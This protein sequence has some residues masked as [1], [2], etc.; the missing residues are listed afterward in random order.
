M[1]DRK[2][3]I[4]QAIVDDYVA[5]AT[6][7]GSRTIARKYLPELSSA[8]I[9]NEM[10][11]L[12][13]MGYLSQPHVSAGRVPSSKAYRLYVDMLLAKGIQQSA[14]EEAVKSAFQTRISHLED[15][16]RSAAQALAELTR[17]ASFVLM[18]RQES[19]RIAN[20]QLVP[21]S[22]AL[23]L[24]VI[25]TDGGII[26]DT[27]VKVSERLDAD[28]LYAISKMLSEQFSGRTLQEVQTA[29][30]Q[31]AGQSPGDPQVLQGIMDLST[32]MD[33]QNAEDQLTICGTHNILGFP[34][35]QEA[36]K[37]RQ[38]LY[39]LDDKE[40][41]LNLVRDTRGEELLVHIGPE[42]GIE[43]MRSCS[44]AVAEYRFSRGQRGTIGL[45]GP[46]RMPYQSIFST[47]RM[48][49]QVMN[50]ILSN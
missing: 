1:E 43:E 22:K 7:V 39:A 14:Q 40:A 24:L 9:R 6:P 18:P 30:R 34:E 10:S 17:Y 32:Q 16:V 8:T 4:L 37:A 23:A 41:L 29:L 19:L 26:R 12:E 13:E 42:N 11:D 3:R 20:L 28:A 2:Q 27:M 21:V 5:T 15:V 46:T 33:S 35:Y 50:D 47:L 49:S 31:F 25:V 36:D 45:I 48:A 44:V 38:L